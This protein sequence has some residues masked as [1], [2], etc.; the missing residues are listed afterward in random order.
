M[1]R[2][3]ILA[4]LIAG[5]EERFKAQALEWKRYLIREA[6][7]KPSQIAIYYKP[8]AP[9]GGLSG[10]LEQAEAFFF[11][12]PAADILL[13]YTGHGLVGSFSP[14]THESPISY[15]KLAKLIPRKSKT[16]FIND[17][18]YSGSCIPIFWEEGILPEKGLVLTSADSTE[19]SYGNPFHRNILQAFRQREPY[20]EREITFFEE[21]CEIITGINYQINPFSIRQH[22]QRCGLD[23]DHLLFP[24]YHGHPPL[25]HS[26]LPR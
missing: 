7:I 9:V 18:C 16:I 15:R 19:L 11:S 2:K 5:D 26:L 10:V 6:W 23:L 12:P 25:Q 21:K 4:F 22:P 1:I 3:D 8:E 14:I 17:S 20:K 13:L 24:L